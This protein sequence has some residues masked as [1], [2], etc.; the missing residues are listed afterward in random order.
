M[1]KI[2]KTEDNK[3]SQISKENEEF[4]NINYVFVDLFERNNFFI[5][6]NNN[7][8]LEMKYCYKNSRNYDFHLIC[9]YKNNLNL[10]YLFDDINE[11]IINSEIKDEDKKLLNNLLRNNCL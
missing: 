4:K 9:I 8:K 2:W 3:I 7:D 10:E 5:I 6:K 11:L 1:I